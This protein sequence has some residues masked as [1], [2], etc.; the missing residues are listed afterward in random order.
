MKQ[1]IE[2]FRAVAADGYE[3]TIIVY[4]EFID[5]GT[6]KN[7]NAVVPG[8]REVRT[9]DGFAC[10][11]KDEDTFEIVNDPLHPSLIVRRSR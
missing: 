10:N 2:R 7:P 5:T 4:Q 1:E 8:L 3:T 9:I 11:C 6:R